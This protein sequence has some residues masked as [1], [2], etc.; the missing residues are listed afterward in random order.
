MFFQEVNMPKTQW[1]QVATAAEN[2][3]GAAQQDA[4]NTAPRSLG[5]A[6]C[7]ITKIAS[8]VHIKN[9]VGT[10]GSQ[11]TFAIG[12]VRSTS[13]FDLV[14]S[15]KGVTDDV[16]G[17]VKGMKAMLL[18]QA[19]IHDVGTVQTGLHAEMAIVRFCVH[20]LGIAKAELGGALQVVCVG[21]KVCRDCAGWMN[22]HGIG[23]CAVVNGDNGGEV[24]FAAGKVSTMGGGIWK[25]PLT[26]GTYSGG[27][28]LN[29]YS[30]DGKT[31]NRPL[32][33]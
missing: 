17:W 1:N 30:K 22:Q 5:G 16:I 19:D 33:W 10:Y 8:N 26:L 27:N 15:L 12:F 6:M 4:W 25:N 14:V 7:N 23:H 18:P 21:K 9:I 11:Q 24:K 31:I 32:G 20:D 29:H 2:R 13:G 28:D 3:R